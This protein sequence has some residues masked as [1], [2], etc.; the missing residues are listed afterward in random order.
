[1]FSNNHMDSKSSQSSR[2]SSQ[3]TGHSGIR[4]REYITKLK[5]DL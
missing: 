5:D 1:M 4:G 2:F 3:N